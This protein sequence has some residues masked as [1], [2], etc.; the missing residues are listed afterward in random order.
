MKKLT[1]LVLVPLILAACATTHDLMKVDTI[2]QVVE[3]KRNKS[4]L[5]AITNIWT[6][7]PFEAGICRV[8]YQQENVGVIK[9][10]MIIP[11][12]NDLQPKTIVRA[13]TYPK[14]IEFS[15]LIEM[16]DKKARLS[17]YDVIQRTET[18]EGIGLAAEME[19]GYRDFITDLVKKYQTFV[20]TYNF[21]W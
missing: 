6:I 15:F 5:F 1:I 18:S 17:F 3:T 10:R 11:V 16:K 8:E 13:L 14:E 4:E 9:G 19:P 21:D 12:Q 7:R 20:D 2:Q